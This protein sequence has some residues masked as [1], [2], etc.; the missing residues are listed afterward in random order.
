M[1][2]ER[3]LEQFAA[4]FFLSVRLNTYQDLVFEATEHSLI[5]I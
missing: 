2:K 3:W 4:E 1:P 5:T